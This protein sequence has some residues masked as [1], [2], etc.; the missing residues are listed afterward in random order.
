M[1][2]TIFA[3]MYIKIKFILYNLLYI[4]IYIVYIIYYKYNI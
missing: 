4:Y 1:K 2:N 3:Y